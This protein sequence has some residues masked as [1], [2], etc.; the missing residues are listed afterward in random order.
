MNALT[1]TS[2]DL[3]MEPKPLQDSLITISQVVFPRD[4]NELGLATAGVIMKGID[5]AASL[6]AARHSRRKI[7]TASLDRMNFINPARLWE[8]VTTTCFLTKTWRSS[9]EVEVQVRAENMR[10]GE[11][12]CVAVGY[13]VFVALD[14]EM[15]KPTAIPP[16]AITADKEQ[17]R[18]EEAEARK[19][20][21]IQELETIGKHEDTL[22]DRSDMPQSV[23]RTMT[24][25]DS[26]IHQN[27]FGGIIL[28]LIH[29]AG[30]KVAFR[31]VN[32]PVIAV[33]Q[34]RMSFEQPAYIGEE[35]KAE[36][37]ITRTW[38]T[39]MEV[40]VDVTA[41]DHKTQ[42]C[43]KVASSYL[44]FVAQAPDGKPRPLAPF[45]PR[46]PKQRQ[47]W[48]EADIRRAVRLKERT[49][50]CPDDAV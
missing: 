45:E 49:L 4:T 28:E 39:S 3:T 7:V 14:D 25:N 15:H 26:N 41:R 22:I 46:T 44:V 6:T 43:R 36:A 27:V 9:M 10:T 50:T 37:V 12:R 23:M 5:I 30:E 34:D 47:R 1:P 24:P 8:L 29:H 16:L 33:R 13:L 21:R 38:N 11:G 20:S 32:G 31:H 19:Q 42:E 18:A 17:R 48:E 35:V 2:P 40:Q